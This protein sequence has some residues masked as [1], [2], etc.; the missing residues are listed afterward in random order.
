MDEGRTNTPDLSNQELAEIFGVA[1]Q[2]GSWKEADEAVFRLSGRRRNQKTVRTVIKSSNIFRGLNRQ[3]LRDLSEEGAMRIAERVGYDANSTRV[4]T[5]AAAYLSW[6]Q[7]TDESVESKI[8]QLAVERHQVKL[9]EVVDSLRFNL[10]VPTPEEAAFVIPDS[11]ATRM[12]DSASINEDLRTLFQIVNRGPKTVKS[13]RT[14]EAVFFTE[15]FSLFPEFLEHLTGEGLQNDFL[16]LKDVLGRHAA[17]CVRQKA[18]PNKGDTSVAAELKVIRG[19]AED[20][21]KKLT[22]SMQAILK[23][24]FM[25]GRCQSC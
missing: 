14:F 11:E 5:L 4:Q 18:Q 1:E 19:R 20:L 7:G 3:E 17:L 16:E 9:L 15:E 8:R 24:G 13:N 12:D 10:K 23:R 6:K 25:A 22:G 2:G 21:T